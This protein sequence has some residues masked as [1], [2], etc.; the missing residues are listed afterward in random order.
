LVGAILLEW[1]VATMTVIGPAAFL[2][3]YWGVT[4]TG[5][6]REGGHVIFLSTW[7]FLVWAAGDRIPTWV[8][9][10]SFCA[11]RA[12]EVYVTLF[13]PALV[14]G[15]WGGLWLLNDLCWLAVSTCCVATA[16]WLSARFSKPGELGFGILQSPQRSFE[17]TR[18]GDPVSPAHFF[19]TA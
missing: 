15:S 4:T 8:F 6:M 11:V 7:I 1:R 18:G 5:L 2:L 17:A 10:M 14:S 9:G 3:L 16:V 12:V 19:T 13:A